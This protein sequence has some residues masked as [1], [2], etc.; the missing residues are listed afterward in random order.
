MQIVLEVYNKAVPS[1]R[2]VTNGTFTCT[3]Q[4]FTQSFMDTAY[5]NGESAISLDPNDGPM[6]G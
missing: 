5:K 4:P 1:F 6:I 3:F 2:R